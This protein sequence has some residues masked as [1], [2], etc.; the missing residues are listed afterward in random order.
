MRKA[1]KPKGWWFIFT[2]KRLKIVLTNYFRAPDIKVLFVEMYGTYGFGF[3]FYNARTGRTRAV[4]YRYPH[5]VRYARY[6]Y[7]TAV[8]LRQ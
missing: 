4:P 5:R 1:K 3:C 6:Q 2:S 7:G 8:R